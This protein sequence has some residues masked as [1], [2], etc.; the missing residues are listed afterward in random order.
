MEKRKR[1]FLLLLISVLLTAAVWSGFLFWQRKHSLELPP[2][3]Q[4]ELRPLSPEID[5]G[6]IDRLKKRKIE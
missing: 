1:K 5:T 2:L 4:E 6:V 3:S